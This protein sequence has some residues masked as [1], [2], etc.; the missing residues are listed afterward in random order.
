M[1]NLIDLMFEN[2][3]RGSR[4][5]NEHTEQL[6]AVRRIRESWQRRQMPGAV[7]LASPVERDM[8]ILLDEIERLGEERDALADA[9]VAAAD[10]ADAAGYEAREALSMEDDR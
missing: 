2:A 5:G 7:Q 6:L 8:G 3:E 1:P 9:L 4:P 10:S